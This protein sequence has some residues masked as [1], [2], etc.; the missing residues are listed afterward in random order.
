MGRHQ[1]PMTNVDLSF[2]QIVHHK[3]CVANKSLRNSIARGKNGKGART[4]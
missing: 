2:E 3:F 4:L 1:N